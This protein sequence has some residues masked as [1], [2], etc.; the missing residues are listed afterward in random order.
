MQ[1]QKVGARAEYRQE[2]GERI[3]NSASIAKKFPEL[4]TLTVELAY[5]TSDGVNRSSQF[6]YKVN[7]DNAKSVFWFDCLN[8]ECVRGDFDLGD[9]LSNAVSGHCT[10]VNGKKRCLGW[11]NKTSI[12]SVRC[13]NILRYKLTLGYKPV[14]FLAS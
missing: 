14:G 10:S 3:R 5:Y 4:K 13:H 11:L 9:D 1:P 12:G 8:K 7:L 2:E 6:K